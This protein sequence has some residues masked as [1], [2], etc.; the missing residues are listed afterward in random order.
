MT[1]SGVV[2]SATILLAFGLGTLGLASHPV[3][4]AEGTVQVA[5]K[6]SLTRADEKAR[7]P[8]TPD[9]MP[10][11]AITRL[12]STR[13]RHAATATCVTFSPDGQRLI[14]GGQDDTLHVW[15]VGTGE[16][17]RSIG[18][19]YSPVAIRFT[20]DGQRLAV[21]SGDGRIHFLD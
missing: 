2:R 15:E 1:A 5:Q 10:E 17:L 8:R 12:G 9:V 3:P 21:A 18:L 11:G 14:S 13:L 4:G 20:P 19:K 16:S 6:K 7:A